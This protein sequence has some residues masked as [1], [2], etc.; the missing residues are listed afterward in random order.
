MSDPVGQNPL[1]IKSLDW[2]AE[3]YQM[4]I[5]NSKTRSE[6]A[7]DPDFMPYPEEF[8]KD[9]TKKADSN[10]LRNK[11]LVLQFVKSPS[12]VNPS[13]TKQETLK[14]SLVQVLMIKLWKT[15]QKQ[16]LE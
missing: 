4:W 13:M 10:P 16:L 7:T 6:K 14:I 3:G 9:S 1:C 8:E 11:A 2:S 5:V 12:S 15:N